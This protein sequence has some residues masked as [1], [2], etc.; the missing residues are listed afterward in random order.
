MREAISPRV[1]RGD[2]LLLLGGGADRY[3]DNVRP[4]ISR[5][6]DNLVGHSLQDCSIRMFLG[7]H[8]YM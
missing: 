6:F 2:P 1:E 3:L 5:P 4:C 8:V 7:I